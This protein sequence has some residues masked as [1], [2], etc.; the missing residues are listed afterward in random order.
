[1]ARSHTLEIYTLVLLHYIG[2]QAGIGILIGSQD[3]KGKIT[4]KF[5]LKQEQNNGFQIL[6]GS[7]IWAHTFRL[8]RK[9]L[10]LGCGSI[11]VK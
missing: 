2:A 4:L 10:K 5:F 8:C 1:M 7:N 3:M 11:Y 9:I 6:W